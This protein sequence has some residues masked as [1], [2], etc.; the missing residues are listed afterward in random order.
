MWDNTDIYSWPYSSYAAVNNVRNTFLS[1]SLLSE[2]NFKESVGL[3]T[4]IE[5]AGLTT[6]YE[7]DAMNRLSAV[8]LSERHHMSEMAYQL[9]R[10][11]FSV[12]VNSEKSVYKAGEQVWLKSSVENGSQ[13]LSYQWHIIG[14][15]GKE[16]AVVNAKSPQLREAIDGY[17]PMTAT[18][19][20]TDELKGVS[21]SGLAT[22]TISPQNICFTD[23]IGS[24]ESVSA[25]LYCAHALNV[26]F[27]VM[28]GVESDAFEIL[29]D[30]MDYSNMVA[31]GE[32]FSVNLS[33]G[34]HSVELIFTDDEAVGDVILYILKVEGTH[35][36]TC[37]HE[38]IM[39]SR[40]NRMGADENDA[41]AVAERSST[42]ES[43]AE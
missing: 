22:F 30:G 42:I 6:S 2:F 23:I 33:P 31:Y 21:V 14:Q 28:L 18:C 19:I 11:D 41:D 12:S 8:N 27:K 36:E 26:T 1:K 35:G 15:D 5:P 29:I 38:P 10:E 9:C 43:V 39:I 7:Y 4:R 13:R 32:Q 16:L 24:E 17:G 3:S 20:V 25:N 34:R 37:N 40:L